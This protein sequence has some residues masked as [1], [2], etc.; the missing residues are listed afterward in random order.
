MTDELDRALADLT[1]KKDTWARLPIERK[2]SYLSLLRAAV[3]DKAG[4][5]VHRSMAGKHLPNDSPLAG[6]EWISGPYAVLMS[7]NALEKTLRAI[8]SGGDVLS[9]TRIRTRGGGQI[10]VEVFPM[11]LYDRLLLHGYRAEVWMQEGVTTA[12]LR[13]HVGTFY[14]RESPAG[15]VGLILGAGNIS[16]IPILDVLTKMFIEGQVSIVK[17]NPVNDYLGTT[18]E[19]IMAPLIEDGYLRFVY[20]GGDVGT[21][22]TNHDLVDALHITGSADTYNTIVFGPGEAGADRRHRNEPLITKPFTSELGGVGPTIVVP[23]PWTDPD[24]AYQ[25][26]HLAT[27]KFHN[28]G[29]NCI[30][31]Q[32]LVLPESWE[33]SDRLVDELRRTIRSIPPREAYYPGAAERQQAA[34]AKHPHA[35]V[36]DSGP[37]PRTLITDVDASGKDEY[38]FTTEFFGGVYATTKLAG[39]D[40]ASFVQE[41][42]RFANDKLSGTLG[43]QFLIHPETIEEL[44]PVL[45]EAIADLEYGNVGINSWTGAGYLL[46]TAT[47]GAY[48]G[49][50]HD[51]IGS[52]MGVVHNAFMFDWPEKTVTYAPFHPFPRALWSG[53][54]TLSPKPPW[55]VTHRRAH[56]AGERL[57]RFA[58]D[59]GW[60]HL[61]GLFVAALRN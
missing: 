29:F 16:S 31:S 12:N 54:F 39:G 34:V 45:D 22:L 59:P 18:F 55:F 50:T 2:L 53:S 27:Q 11:D 49:H 32:V 14:K 28:A 26:E 19:E 46:P 43:A 52:G 1:A 23:G 38:A 61:P 40:A 37:V 10:V 5:W 60:K 33:G 17:M 25:A 56:D 47:W 48:P 13:D 6:E 24:F 51:N 57:T 30:A 9:G 7:I 44:G 4:E 15:K 41:A 21:Y 42:V 35:E 58:A 20:G 3:A 8:A 36:L